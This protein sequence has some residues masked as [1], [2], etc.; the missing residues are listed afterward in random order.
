MKPGTSTLALLV[1]PYDFTA[2]SCAHGTSLLKRQV[3]ERA[4]TDGTIKTVAIG[5]FGYIGDIGP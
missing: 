5:T 1:G 3:S 4:G 2:A